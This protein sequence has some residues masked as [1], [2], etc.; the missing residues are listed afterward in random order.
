MAPR[1]TRRRGYSRQLQ[2]TLFAGYVAAVVGVVVAIALVLVARF[3]PPAFQ[4]LRGAFLDTT[5]PLSSAGRSVVRGGALV[6]DEVSAYFDAANQNRALREELAVAR[7]Q[8]IAARATQFENRRLKRVVGLLDKRV[9]PIVVARLIGS[10]ASGYRRF[11]TLAAGFSAGVRPGQPVRSADGLVGRI[12]ETGRSAAR[13]LLLSD[14]GS[15]IPVRVARSGQPAL[16]TG[17]GDGTLTARALASGGRPFR[18]GD[19]LVTSG[20]GGIYAPN[21]PVAVV[22]SVDRELAVAR[23]LADPSRL[24]FAIVDPVFQVPLPPTADPLQREQP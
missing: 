19:L 6:T 23:P 5:A 21:V 7:R 13:V 15:T 11:A 24:D 17:R 8:L 2:Y 4:V 9:P 16:V 14:G 22:M 1:R 20:T 18:R 3:D 12:F 10:D